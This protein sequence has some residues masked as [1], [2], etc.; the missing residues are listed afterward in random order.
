MKFQIK[1]WNGPGPTK[2][3][4][5]CKEEIASAISPQAEV[6]VLVGNQFL[7]EE[8][9]GYPLYAS[10]YQ[11]LDVEEFEKL[12]IEGSFQRPGRKPVSNCSG[13]S[14]SHSTDWV[15]DGYQV[16]NLV[17]EIPQDGLDKF[18]ILAEKIRTA[19]V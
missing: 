18:R 5:L 1:F 3:V 19:K 7:K 13:P 15:E 14:W 9:T 8:A 6:S 17:G 2:I 11:F 4:D 10:S 12:V 16:I